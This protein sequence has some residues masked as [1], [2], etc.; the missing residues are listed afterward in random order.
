M[1]FADWM[2]TFP[3]VG[4]LGRMRQLELEDG[5]LRKKKKKTVRRI[6][7]QEK[8]S[9]V[10]KHRRRNLGLCGQFSREILGLFGF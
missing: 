9:L 2:T 7:I 5:V 4:R 1:G 8:M 6:A 10:M 3:R